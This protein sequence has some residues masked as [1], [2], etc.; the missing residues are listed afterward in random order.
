MKFAAKVG[1]EKK[2]QSRLGGT[3]SGEQDSGQ[4]QNEIQAGDAHGPM[5][6]I[7]ALREMEQEKCG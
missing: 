2:N 1:W 7:L 4:Q 3:M 6:I 5:L